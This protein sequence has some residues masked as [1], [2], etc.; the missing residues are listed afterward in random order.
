[1]ALRDLFQWSIPSLKKLYFVSK[2]KFNFMEIGFCN[3]FD[4]RDQVPTISK[5][6][7][8]HG[9]F[10]FYHDNVSMKSKKKFH[11]DAD[12]EIV[13]FSQ[14]GMCSINYFIP[15]IALKSVIL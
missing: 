12:F 6:F 3:S 2:F 10:L 9:D 13:G 15:E 11:K 7:S 8:L 14:Q 5:M 1:M 4:S